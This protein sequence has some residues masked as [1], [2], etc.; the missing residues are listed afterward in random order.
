MVGEDHYRL[1]SKGWEQNQALDEKRFIIIYKYFEH[2]RAFCFS[3]RCYKNAVLMLYYLKTS[4]CDFDSRTYLT[5][6]S[7][8]HYS[9][10]YLIGISISL[11]MIFFSHSVKETSRAAITRCEL[12]NL[13]H[14]VLLHFLSY[15]STKSEL[16]IV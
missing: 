6:T 2:L 14:W 8:V 4:F 13:N 12:Q 3:L 16:K 15:L 7:I 10:G 1:R 9:V 5:L 11:A